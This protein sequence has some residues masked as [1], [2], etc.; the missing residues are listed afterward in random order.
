MLEADS[1][2]H[3]FFLKLN[4]SKDELKEPYTGKGLLNTDDR[5]SEILTGIIMILT[6]T[7]TFSV[8]K[9]D[10]ASV[11]HML[12]GAICSTMAWGFIDAVMYLFMTLIDKEHN[13]TFLNFIRK[14]NDI[15]KIHQVIIDAL[16]ETIT[17]VMHPDEIEGIRK[18]ILKLPEPATI[19]RLKFNDYKTAGG[20]YILVFFAT[21][22]ISIPFMLIKDLQVALRISNI[23]AILMMFLCGWVLGKY[24]GR[25][26]FIMGIMTSLI[27]IVL[28]L[29]TILSGG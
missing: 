12:T 29:V 16:P 28:V 7:C 14:S 26:R 9:S 5:V 3:A 20:I 25:N 15:K 23:I 18:K 13:L 17:D 8:I 24:A 27:G 1:K 4:K 6:F 21:I 2:K 10:T 19:Y 11:I 22:P